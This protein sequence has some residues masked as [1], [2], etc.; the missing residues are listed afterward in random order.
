[1]QSVRASSFVRSI[2]GTHVWPIAL[3]FSLTPLQRATSV[4]S[5][6]W[7]SVMHASSTHAAPLHSSNC[8][9]GRERGGKL[10]AQQEGRHPLRDCLVTSCPWLVT[11]ARQHSSLPSIGSLRDHLAQPSRPYPSRGQPSVFCRLCRH[12]L[13]ERKPL[14]K[15]AY[16]AHS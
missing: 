13:R 10:E 9:G 15:R 14:H 12:A 6:A 2:N 4:A 7:P 1:M 8:M 16:V 5:T 3:A 11:S